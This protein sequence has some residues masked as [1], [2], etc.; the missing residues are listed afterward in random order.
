[1]ILKFLVKFFLKT[2]IISFIYKFNLKILK[3]NLLAIGYC[4][5]WRPVVN[6]SNNLFLGELIFI[7]KLNNLNLKSCID[8]GANTGEYSF[9][10][11]KNTKLNCIAFEPIKECILSL[12]RLKKK[13]RNR[14]KIY[15]IAISNI[16][17]K[18][19]LYYGDNNYLLSS[20]EKKIN[21]ITKVKNNN[22][23]K[24]K[25]QNRYA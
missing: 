12:G 2:N 10:I 19:N 15:N 16:K 21:H 14:L 9:E 6:K 3:I 1:M 18:K 17:S 22:K 25:M 8:I 23:K 13:F 7:K 4:T 24:N 5:S 11:L 20:F